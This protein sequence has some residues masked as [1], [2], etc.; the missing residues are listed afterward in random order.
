MIVSCITLERQFWTCFISSV[1][2][3]AKMS[4]LTINN[5]HVQVNVATLH[6]SYA[7]MTT[8]FHVPIVSAKLRLGNSYILLA[9]HFHVEYM[10]TMQVGM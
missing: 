8:Y 7:Y 6:K 5:A 10:A 2:Q 4:V 9:E 1:A 3:I